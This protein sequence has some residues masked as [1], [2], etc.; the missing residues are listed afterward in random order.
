MKTGQ[1]FNLFFSVFDRI[2]KI[3]PQFKHKLDTLYT[4]SV[5]SGVFLGNIIEFNKV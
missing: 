1:E 5:S 4:Y 3:T 2:W